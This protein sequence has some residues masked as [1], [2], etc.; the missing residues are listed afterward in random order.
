MTSWRDIHWTQIGRIW[1]RNFIIFRRTWLISLFWILLE[2]I[3]MLGALGFGLGSFIKT[4]GGY[5]YVEFFYP[6][7]LCTSSMMVAFFESSYGNFTKLTYSKVYASQLLSP[8][9]GTELIIGDIFWA[10]TKGTLSGIGIL[11]V[12]GFFG[13]GWSLGTF[14]FL[15]VLFLNAWIFS[16]IGMLVTSF[17]RNYDQIIYPTSGLIVPMSLFSGTYFP[18]TD[19]HPL[20]KG[21][22][23]LL[24]LTHVVDVSRALILG[25]LSSF[26]NPF[27]FLQ[28]GIIF[29]IAVALTRFA[30]YRMLG[31]LSL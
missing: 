19:L 11:I 2:P 4:M 30:I 6:G 26:E 28:L 1:Y 14:P 17:V 27:I 20:L 15:V 25:G 10:A 5:S 7:L 23:Y 8:I 24:P 31:R 18:V 22:F 13:L 3:F 12:G 29:L 16:C 21:F 9:T